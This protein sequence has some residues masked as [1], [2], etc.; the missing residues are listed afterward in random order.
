MADNLTVTD[1]KH[2]RGLEVDLAQAVWRNQSA[3]MGRTEILEEII[4]ATGIMERLKVL[5][6]TDEVLRTL[7]YH[8]RK[9]MAYASVSDVLGA[10]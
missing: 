3:K 5:A 8:L 9:I 1:Y 6:L 4:T 2:I 7:F 10:L